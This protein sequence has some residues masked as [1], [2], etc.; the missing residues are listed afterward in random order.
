MPVVCDGIPR[1]LLANSSSLRDRLENI[2]WEIQ[3]KELAINKLQK[4]KN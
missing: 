4:E 3:Q 1:L 2:L